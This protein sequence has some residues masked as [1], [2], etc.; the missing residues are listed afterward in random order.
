MSHLHLKRK[1]DGPLLP[2]RAAKQPRTALR[3]PDGAPA[4]PSN[5]MGVLSRWIASAADI[6]E[7]GLNAVR[8][9]SLL[10]PEDHQ[11]ER[12]ANG[13]ARVAPT[14]SHASR[15]AEAGPSRPPPP[16]PMTRP[17]QIPAPPSARDAALMPPPPVPEPS[18]SASSSSSSNL[19]NPNAPADVRIAKAIEERRRR[20]ERETGVPRLYENRPHIY[21]KQHK[22]RV[23]EAHKLDFEK[24][25]REIFEIKRRSG[26]SSSE[27]EFRRYLDYK[28]AVDRIYN[29]DLLAPSPSVPNL[30]AYY[31]K[32]EARR[33]SDTFSE[34]FLRRELQRARAALAE[35][36]PTP[37]IP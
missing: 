14:D 5:L 27:E 22:E 15:R 4:A 17:L 35:P 36:K 20:K 13:N 3:G 18:S 26:Y 25:R 28:E 30:R 21:A 12:L 8:D 1:A 2:L 31:A 11:H 29:R 7:S 24:T 23:R 32:D 34:S 6:M 9:L 10:P 33:R 37:F 19:G 16:P